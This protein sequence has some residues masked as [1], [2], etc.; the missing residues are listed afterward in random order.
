MIVDAA[1]KQVLDDA[2]RL[3]VEERAGL[4]VE[5]LASLPPGRERS[6]PAWI[7]EVERRARVALAG[8]PGVTWD[9]ARKQIEARLNRDR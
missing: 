1:S 8:E 7:A 9:V 4:V 2:L 5:L 6:D 3:P